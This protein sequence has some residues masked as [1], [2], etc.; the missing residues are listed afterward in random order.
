MYKLSIVYDN[1]DE[2]CKNFSS[3]READWYAHME[4]DHVVSYI[5]EKITNKE[6]HTFIKKDLPELF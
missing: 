4:G 3:Y 2:E 5:I 1:G 6:P